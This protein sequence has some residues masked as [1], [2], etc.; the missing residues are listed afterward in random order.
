M[1]TPEEIEKTRAPL[2]YHLEEFRARLWK[3]CMAL[4]V[5]FCVSYYF[6]DYIYAFLV[7]PLAD[8][9]PN[10]Q[11]RHLIYTGLAEAF[12][13]YVHLSLFAGFLLA[14]PVIAYQFYMFLAPGMYKTE[15]SVLKPYLVIS[16]IL[17]FLGAALAYYYIFPLAWKFFLSFE[18]HG[19][20]G[21]PIEL[22]ARVS[23]YLSLV[24]HVIIAFGLAFQL[25]VILTLCARVGLVNARMLARGRKYAVLVIVIVAA[26][27]TPPDMLSQIGLSIP[28]YLLYELSILACRKIEKNRLRANADARP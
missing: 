23:E 17:F 9:Y 14:F 4:V 25:P 22:E 11:S 16:P 18:T 28:L 12:I 26:F 27:L 21:M 8:S 15:R 10:P 19:P 3:A 5:G 24:M 2:M 13:T 20:K 1:T 6:S 7:Q